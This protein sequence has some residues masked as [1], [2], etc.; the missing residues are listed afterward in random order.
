MGYIVLDILCKVLALE[1]LLWN[2]VS[3]LEFT[4]DVPKNIRHNVKESM[5]LTAVRANMPQSITIQVEITSKSNDVFF[6][7]RILHRFTKN[8]HTFHIPFKVS[9]PFEECQNSELETDDLCSVTLSITVSETF[10]MLWL[11]RVTLNVVKTPGRIFIQTDRP[12]YFPGDEAYVRFMPLTDDFVLMREKSLLTIESPGVGETRM[13]SWQKSHTFTKQPFVRKF[14]IPHD[15]LLGEWKI[16]AKYSSNTTTDEVF[17][18]TFNV[19]Y[20]S[21]PSF[22]VNVEYIG[23]TFILPEDE[24]FEIKFLARSFHNKPITGSGQVQFGIVSIS[25][26]DDVT[27]THIINNLRLVDGESRFTIPVS[28]LLGEQTISSVSGK[29]LLVIASVTEH[30]TGESQTIREEKIVFSMEPYIMKFVKGRQ[31]FQPGVPVLTNVQL[32]YPDGTLSIGVD[33]EF[34]IS[35]VDIFGI[36]TELHRVTS[37]TC[38]LGTAMTRTTQVTQS[39]TTTAI[40]VTTSARFTGHNGHVYVTTKSELLSARKPESTEYIHI[41]AP[42]ERLQ[43]DTSAVIQVYIKASSAD[44]LIHYYITKNGKFLVQQSATVGRGESDILI[45]LPII[46]S[47]SPAITMTV[48]YFTQNFQDIVE[49]RTVLYIEKACYGNTPEVFL[50]DPGGQYPRPGAQLNL[51]VTGDPESIISMV[52]RDQAVNSFD[53]ASK[54]E[55]AEDLEQIRYSSSDVCKHGRQYFGSIHMNSFSVCDDV[56][57]RRKRSFGDK[58]MEA[59]MLRSRYPMYKNNFPVREDDTKRSKRSIVDKAIGA[60]ILTLAYKYSGAMFEC[61]IVGARDLSSVYHTP[62]NTTCHERQHRVHVG[63]FCRHTF[64]KCCLIAECLR[65]T[66]DSLEDCM[67]SRDK[68]TD[69]F[70]RSVT[71]TFSP[72]TQE[73]KTSFMVEKSVVLRRK[74]FNPTW[75]FVDFQMGQSGRKIL[76]NASMPSIPVLPDRI[77]TWKVDVVGSSADKPLCVGIPLELPVEHNVYIDVRINE[78]PVV[79]GT[80]VSAEVTI[81]NHIEEEVEANLYLERD[82]A[83][84]SKATLHKGSDGSQYTLHPASGNNPTTKTARYVMIPLRSGNV[85]IKFKLLARYGGSSQPKVDLVEKT[86]KVLPEGEHKRD[87][88]W[89]LVDSNPK[90]YA[91]GRN[92]KK[93]K[94]LLLNIPD[95][96]IPGSEEV[97][98]SVHSIP[99]ASMD[100]P[101]K[102]AAESITIQDILYQLHPALSKLQ[103]LRNIGAIKTRYEDKLMETIQESYDGLLG[104]LRYV[105]VKKLGFSVS[106]DYEHFGFSYSP[107]TTSTPS[108]HLTSTVFELLYKMKEFIEIDTK[109]LGGSLHWILRHQ[110]PLGYFRTSTAVELNEKESIRRSKRQ[111]AAKAQDRLLMSTSDKRIYITSTVLL[112]LLSVKEIMEN[113][114]EFNRDDSDYISIDVAILNGKIYLRRKIT[115]IIQHSRQWSAVAFSAAA[116]ILKRLGDRVSFKA[117]SRAKLW[118]RTRSTTND[119]NT[120]VAWIQNQRYNPLK[121]V[122]DERDVETNHIVATSHMLRHAILQGSKT[123]EYAN[124][125]I[126][127]RNNDGYWTSFRANMAAMEAL[128]QYTLHANTASNMG[129]LAIQLDDLANSTIEINGHDTGDNIA[130]MKLNVATPSIGYSTNGHGKA[131][132]KID[133]SYRTVD[134]AVKSNKV[135]MSPVKSIKSQKPL[136]CIY[137]VVVG[138]QES[139][140]TFLILQ[141]RSSN[142]GRLA[143]DAKLSVK[144]NELYTSNEDFQSYVVEFGLPIGSHAFESDLQKLSNPVEHIIDHYRLTG[145]SVFLYITGDKDI[146][147]RISDTYIKDEPIPLK[148]YPVSAPEKFCRKFYN[149]PGLPS[150]IVTFCSDQVSSASE[151]CACAKGKTCPTLIKSKKTI[152][153]TLDKRKE[154]TCGHKSTFAYKVQFTKKSTIDKNWYQYEGVIKSIYRNADGT[155]KEIRTS[156]THVFWTKRICKNIP[157]RKDYLIIGH[158]MLP[159]SN[160]KYKH[161]LDANTWIELWP[162]NPGNCGRSSSNTCKAFNKVDEY[163]YAMTVRPCVV[164]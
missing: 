161:L 75:F 109:M 64:L 33:V 150:Q 142:P 15:S 103:F 66:D 149:F 12:V 20:K 90:G 81:Y 27:M 96:V 87:V 14:K 52:G 140:S 31:F 68:V 10:I 23:N 152:K 50:N 21:I 38:D 78:E 132:V 145:R 160:G 42:Q 120:D 4:V 136:S 17:Q 62:T 11:E 128:R 129:Q 98:M 106:D 122:L 76:E 138:L 61:C 83:L 91:L 86:L 164:H 53:V 101:H 24:E 88:S 99:S 94:S 143:W 80:Q 154:L 163:E 134:A 35:S 45:H 113:H 110:V 56:A 151:L 93:K 124:W 82:E 125:L 131:W 6:T 123:D 97:T 77:T 54:R 28:S 117:A 74:D 159:T 121:R 119:A 116:E 135:K 59:P 44:R 111:N 126:Q 147:F 7:D 141:S 47:M 156:T 137:D 19:A 46:S 69:S 114:P 5:I 67:H 26:E 105:K 22:R 95:N 107:V 73:M 34:V 13:M 84:C 43:I 158:A 146:S 9:P 112:N 48:Y 85:K 18:S 36:E 139:I 49:D 92:R 39:E 2:S 57:T 25:D 51:E 115:K 40:K 30:G 148:I 133:S 63:H 8:Y 71:P 55:T 65:T 108:M 162:N 37:E 130:Q 153:T 3:S 29:R 100:N 70:L 60:S 102:P 16:S 58:T 89:V 32:N 157:V 155:N 144:I 1:V 118:K 79:V 127:Q 104:Y 72:F 41:E